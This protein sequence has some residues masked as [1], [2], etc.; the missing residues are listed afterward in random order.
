MAKQRTL[1]DA[2][3]AA[4]KKRNGMTRREFNAKHSK[5]ANRAPKAENGS[6]EIVALFDGNPVPQTAPFPNVAAALARF[7][8]LSTNENIQSLKLIENRTAYDNNGNA[9]GLRQSVLY[10][11]VKTGQEFAN[12]RIEALWRKKG[13]NSILKEKAVFASPSLTK[14]AANGELELFKFIAVGGNP[15][16]ETRT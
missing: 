1:S 12:S 16:W 14:A 13:G 9:V 6:Y 5:F 8:R 15:W 10:S 11:L 2:E 7:E 3:Q 4:R